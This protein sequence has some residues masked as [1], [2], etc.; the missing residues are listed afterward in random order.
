[1]LLH[2]LQL[3]IYNAKVAGKPASHNS[4]S[5]STTFSHGM[6]M[7][8]EICLLPRPADLMMPKHPEFKSHGAKK[9]GQGF[10]NPSKLLRTSGTASMLQHP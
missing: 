9:D 7:Y 1:M 5:R 6:T 10:T 2:L 3:T 8:H 4:A